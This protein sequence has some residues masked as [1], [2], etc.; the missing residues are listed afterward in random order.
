MR[1]RID[2]DQVKQRLQAAQQANMQSLDSERLQKILAA[3][4]AR[5]AS[6]AANVEAQA[7]SLSLLTF[8]LG[9]ECY[10]LELEQLSEVLPLQQVTPIPDAPPELT[11]VINLR[12]E[13]VTVVDLGRILELPASQTSGGYILLLRH[14]TGD[15]GLRVEQLGQVDRVP[16]KD[17]VSTNDPSSARPSRFVAA[18]TPDKTL[19]LSIDAILTHAV[20]ITG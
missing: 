13:I 8:F 12:G 7:E 15:L 6:R 17:L 2:W 1:K 10:A 18:I 9:G 3:R 14:A 16:K 19:V 11:G 20:F 4:A 5:L